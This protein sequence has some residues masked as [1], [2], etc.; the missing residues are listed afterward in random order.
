MTMMLDIILFITSMLVGSFLGVGF[1]YSLIDT[2]EYRDAKM[3]RE[4]YLKNK[5]EHV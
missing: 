1:L 3:E 2:K 4:I 5:E